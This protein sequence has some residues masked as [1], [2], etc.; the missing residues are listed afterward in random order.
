M[1]IR[2]IG[3]GSL[4][5]PNSSSLQWRFPLAF[6]ALPAFMLFLGMFWLPESPRHLI[7]KD[8]DDEALRIL[9]RLHYDG[10]NIE[11]IQTEFT[12][13][14]ATINAERVLTASGWTIMF[15]VPQWRTRLL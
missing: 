7:E 3:Y 13:I 10:A 11:W 12:E 2:W 15:K 6:Q 1:H 4:H 8:Q 14:K 9:K 5:A